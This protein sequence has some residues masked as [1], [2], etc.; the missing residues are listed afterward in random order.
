MGY[1]T[2]NDFLAFQCV[3]HRILPLACSNAV[4]FTLVSA[5]ISC[6][7]WTVRPATNRREYYA[8]TRWSSCCY[9][10]QLWTHHSYWHTTWCCRANVERL[11]WA[12]VFC[13]IK[14]CCC[15]FCACW[16]RWCCWTYCSEFI[17]GQHVAKLGHFGMSNM[18][19]GWHLGILGSKVFTVTSAVPKNF[20]LEPKFMLNINSFW[21]IDWLI[22][23]LI[24][25]ELYQFQRPC[26]LHPTV[27]RINL[28][29]N[30]VRQTEAWV[31]PD[32][33][34]TTNSW[35]TLVWLCTKC[36]SNEPEEWKA[37]LATPL[38]YELIWHFDARMQ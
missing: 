28:D 2:I 19:A 37:Q 11:S 4:C 12:W 35:N 5:S 25:P 13:C 36:F 22:D 21:L 34:L 30:K 6:Q 29:P 32:V 9:D 20:T 1:I 8:V 3:S 7:V 18:A 33:L 10:R 16:C 27:W 17:N 24:E 26:C 38:Q 31:L 15:Y 14:V 23:W